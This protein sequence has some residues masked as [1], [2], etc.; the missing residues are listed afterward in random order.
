MSF[1]FKCKSADKYQAKSSPK[2]NGGDGCV[3]CNRKW[4]RAN[5]AGKGQRP[6]RRLRKTA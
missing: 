4:E 1:L 3:V 2:C 6:K 5:A